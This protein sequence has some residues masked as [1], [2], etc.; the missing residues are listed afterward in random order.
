MKS[1]SLL[2]L[3]ASWASAMPRPEHSKGALYFLDSDPNGASV[4]SFGIVRDGSLGDPVRTST[5]G[6][7][8]IGNNANGSVTAGE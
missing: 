4:V 5:G 7:G 8:L 1:I 6:N 3:A 2:V